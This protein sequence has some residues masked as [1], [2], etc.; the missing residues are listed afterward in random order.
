MGSKK[1]FFEW[2]TALLLAALFAVAPPTAAAKK[3]HHASKHPAKSSRI[4]G[5]GRHSRHSRN[6][7]HHG[8]QKV[9]AQR[10][11]Q[12]QGALV[13]S[14]Y[15]EGEPSGAWDSM[16]EDALRR[17]QAANGW[18][19]KVVPD[20]RAL[21]KLGLGPSDKKLI[22]PESAMTTGPAPTGASDPGPNAP[23]H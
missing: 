2:I 7:R 14:H 9:D 16:T 15:L 18:Q 5:S 20:S 13:R 10:T 4:K 23:Q 19:S 22:N 21:I 12:I 1:T 6:W 8:Q 11:Q 17:Y 3:R